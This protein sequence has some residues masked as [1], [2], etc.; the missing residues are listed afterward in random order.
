MSD[1]FALT[2]TQSDSFRRRILIPLSSLSEAYR[3]SV[4][5]TSG[6]GLLE[7]VVTHLEVRVHPRRS[8]MRSPKLR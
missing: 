5:K 1:E 6:A 8:T 2:Y 7:E 3:F 4:S